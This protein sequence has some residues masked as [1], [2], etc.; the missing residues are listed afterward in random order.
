MLRRKFI[1]AT[2]LA[3]VIGTSFAAVPPSSEANPYIQVPS[4]VSDQGIVRVFFSPRCSYSK[5]YFQFFTNLSKTMPA[6]YNFE[7]SPAVNR[8]DGIEY[9]MAFLA[10]RR[11]Y[12]TYVQ[13]FIQASLE[14]SQ[15]RMIST[16]SWAGIER[17]GRAAHVPVSLSKLVAD[18]SAI[19]GSDLR[20]LIELQTKLKITNTP[21]VSVAGTYIVT[22]EFVK[23]DQAMFSQLV[24][25]VIS[26]GTGR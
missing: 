22:P 11:F 5:T 20:A 12:P 4:V 2:F 6:E 10:V 3:C 17:L 24:N 25:A 16:S 23:G 8:G 19:I 13:N 1:A 26:M 7:Y 18:N 21:S 9:S 14:G 15:D